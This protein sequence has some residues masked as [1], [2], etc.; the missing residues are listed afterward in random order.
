MTIK[1]GSR[2]LNNYIKKIKSIYDNL[3]TI[4]KPVANLDK[5]FQFAHGLKAKYEGFSLAMVTKPPYPTF[6]QFVLA[7]LGYVQ[8]L[9]SQKEEKKGYIEY[10]Q[11]FFSQHGYGISNRGNQGGF[12]SKGKCFTLGGCYNN[13]G[14]SIN[15]S[16]K[17]GTRKVRQ[18]Q[19]K[20]NKPNWQICR[21]KNHV[22]IGLTTSINQKTYHNFGHFYLGQ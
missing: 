5:I 4:K 12:K 7:L 1:K 18:H 21:K 17:E 11:V 10:N 15:N 6:N 19:D 20:G 16:M 8:T 13:I 22:G 2:S 14:S 3:A 9:V